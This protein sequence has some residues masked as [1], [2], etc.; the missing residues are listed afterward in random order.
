M[1]RL[2]R[3]LAFTAQRGGEQ[4]RAEEQQARP[5]YDA[6]A[7]VLRHWDILGLVKYDNLAYENT[8]I[9]L[10]Q[11]LPEAHDVSSVE[12]LVFQ[13]C[14]EQQESADFS[15]DQS[16][17]IKFLA[18]DVWSAW[19]DYRQRSEQPT[20]SQAHSRARMRRFLLPR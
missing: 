4:M 16:R 2:R 1:K 13:A 7:K 3:H 20:F 12:R 9:W 6:L 14:A 8:V 17:I 18:D 19:T 11:H 5:I 10:L 15:P